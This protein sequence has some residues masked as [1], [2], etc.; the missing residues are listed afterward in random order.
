MSK[1]ISSFTVIKR[2]GLA[3]P[4]A[5]DKMMRTIA[6]LAYG[7]ES[8]SVELVVQELLKTVF[9]GI[10]TTDIEKA[11]TLAAAAFIERDPQYDTLAS[12]LLLQSLRKQVFAQSASD[13]NVMATNVQ[14]TYQDSFISAINQGVAI[15]YL[16]ARMLDFD[17]ERLSSALV[18]ER[19]ELLGYMGLHTLY[20]RYLLKINGQRVELP[21]IFWMRIAMGIALEEADKEEKALAFYA[22]ISTLRYIP[23][24]PTLYHAGF[25]VAQL[26]S[27]YL[28]TV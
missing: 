10:T 4:L 18:V 2:N 15:G 19:D 20:E 13:K 24:T 11:S 1:S 22:V 28:T 12:R 5:E 25:P 21:Q 9:D 16:D 26:S 27:C 23:S 7:L 3:V 14:R 8:V 17:L 6:R